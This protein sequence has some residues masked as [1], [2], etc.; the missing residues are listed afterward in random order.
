MNISPTDLLDVM[1]AIAL[2]PALWLLLTAIGAPLSAALARVTLVRVGLAA[3]DGDN[4]RW[5][6]V[7]AVV[8]GWLVAWLGLST[9]GTLAAMS[10][11]ASL[12]GAA[13]QLGLNLLVGALILASANW[14]STARRRRADD[15]GTLDLELR[16]LTYAASVLAALSVATG[17]GLTGLL[18][19]IAAIAWFWLSASPDASAALRASLADFQAGQLLRKRLSRDAEVVVDGRALTVVGA[20]GLLHTDTLGA[21]GLVTLPNRH[22]LAA[23][24]QTARLA[25]RDSA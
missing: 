16:A 25:P 8:V 14:Y 17:L 6:S 18:L 21:D 1:R 4:I 5:S 12:A 3:Y 7:V 15:D 9:V 22:L 20:A 24:V 13:F 10:A 2:S 23:V 19:L 11:I